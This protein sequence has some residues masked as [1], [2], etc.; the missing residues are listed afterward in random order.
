MF[1]T[2]LVILE[3]PIKISSVY[4]LNNLLI[5]FIIYMSSKEMGLS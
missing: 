5:I 4:N 2:I 3:Y 1:L